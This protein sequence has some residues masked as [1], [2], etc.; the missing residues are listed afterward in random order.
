MAKLASA[1]WTTSVV[2][3][4]LILIGCILITFG[5]SARRPQGG[6]RNRIAERPSFLKDVYHEDNSFVVRIRTTYNQTTS[7][8]CN[9]VVMEDYLVLSDITCIKYQGM[10][11]VDARF[12]QVIAGESNNET[13]YD[14]DQI[15]INKADPKDPTTELALLK[16]NRPLQVDIEC[17]QLL[18]P[19]KNHSIEFDTPVRTIGFT[20]NFEIKENR[21]RIA[22]KTQ[23]NR[24]ICT[25]PGSLNETPGS[26]LLK[27]APL[28]H[29]VDCRRY[30]IVGIYTKLET[31]TENGSS[32]KKH[33]DCY[34]SVS[35]QIKWYDQVRSLATLAAK[36][37]G[38]AQPSLVVVSVDD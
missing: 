31:V 3:G 11:N 7:I 10:F 35:A 34:V 38:S 24:Y 5:Q 6:N 9:A 28:L 16:L 26:Y 30:Q 20:N 4:L 8:T 33:Q 21:S 2:F 18:R 19:E 25:T 23:A 32:Q 29:M 1:Y 17:R 37:D 13:V 15:Y 27:G 14:V 22:K 36:N 12:V